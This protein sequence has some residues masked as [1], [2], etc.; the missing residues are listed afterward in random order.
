MKRLDAFIPINNTPKV[1]DILK[2]NNIKGLTVT[3]SLGRGSGERPWM[4]GSTGHEVDF[5]VI[6]TITIIIDDSQVEKVTKLIMDSGST[7]SP[8]D[9]KIFISPID[10]AV[11]IHTKQYGV[12]AIFENVEK[13]L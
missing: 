9:G 8:G 7:G 1:L 12:K 2:Q 4:G 13:K 6:N 3:E 5:N 11:D 10:D